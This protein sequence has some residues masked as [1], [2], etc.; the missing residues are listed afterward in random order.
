MLNSAGTVMGDRV[1]RASLTKSWKPFWGPALLLLPLVM[2]VL[3]CSD[4]SGLLPIGRGGK[5]ETLVIGIE[6]INRVQ[7][8]RYE[9]T[10]QKH[11]LLSPVS[12]ENELV[13][14]RLNVHNAQ[15]TT[16]FLTVDEAAAELRGFENDESYNPLD[17]HQLD[18]VIG[19]NLRV[20]E[21][22]HPAENRYVP[23]IAGPIDL[24]QGHSVIGWVV[25]EVPRGTRLRELKWDAGDTVYIRG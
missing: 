19:R 10:D 17:M 16:I 21:G 20:V 13:V 8:V 7:E 9:G 2:M 1:D 24:P 22:S 15:A 25:F 12:Q 23:F 3:A 18:E 11:Y 5:G 14:I 4:D 6:D